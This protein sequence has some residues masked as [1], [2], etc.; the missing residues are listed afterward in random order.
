MSSAS[1]D[2]RAPLGRPARGPRWLRPIRLSVRASQ[3]RS[4]AGTEASGARLRGRRGPRVVGRGRST[5]RVRAASGSWPRPWGRPRRPAPAGAGRDRR[6]SAR[7]RQG[8]A[9]GR[10]GVGLAV[11]VAGSGGQPDGRPELRERRVDE[12]AV[13]QHDAP[14][15][16]A[17]PTASTGRSSAREQRPGLGL[18]AVR[19]GDGQRRAARPRGLSLRTGRAATS[20]ALPAYAEHR[21]LRSGASTSHSRLRG[22]SDG[23]ERRKTSSRTTPERVRDQVGLIQLTHVR[24]AGRRR[25][26]RLGH[27]GRADHNYL[28]VPGVVLCVDADVGRVND[29]LERPS[30]TSWRSTRSEPLSDA[31]VE[32]PGRLRADAYAVDRLRRGAAGLLAA[33]DVLDEELGEG[34]VTPDH[35]FH[36]SAT[37]HG[38]PARP[39]SPR[40]RVSDQRLAASSRPAPTPTRTSVTVSVIDTGFWNPAA[41]PNG[42]SEW[43]AGAEA[44]YDG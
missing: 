39:P 21:Y 38:R 1:L 32:R 37:R 5:G 7:H 13:A 26:G 19:V 22:G 33:L 16:A 34:V 35:Y 36:V 31:V 4:P 30:A 27:R 18:G 17:R 2:G 29:V 20:R 23:T 11:H 8:H 44:Q 40:R 41:D 15:L 12:A 25:R 43:L 10:A 42:P 3:T 6:G 28:F 24:G 14:G 9:E